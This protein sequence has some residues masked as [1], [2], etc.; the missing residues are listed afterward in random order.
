[1]QEFENVDGIKEILNSRPQ[2]SGIGVVPL[3]ELK[4]VPTSTMIGR[5]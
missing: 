2:L 4:E 1:M 3:L 5:I